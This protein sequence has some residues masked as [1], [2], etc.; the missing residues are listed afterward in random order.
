MMEYS[1]EMILAVLAELRGAQAPIT[2]TH[3]KSPQ[4]MPAEEHFLVRPEG[5]HFRDET[6]PA[7]TMVAAGSDAP[8]TNIIGGLSRAENSMKNREYI[9]A[10]ANQIVRRLERAS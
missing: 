9:A 7:L 6:L 5:R 2:A 8:A 4:P 10:T 1:D 3:E